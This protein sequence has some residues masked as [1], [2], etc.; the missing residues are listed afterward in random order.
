[1]V[2]AVANEWMEQIL[3]EHRQLRTTVA[4][5]REYLDGPRPRPGEKGSHTWAARLSERILHL[6]DELVRHF[7]FE[8]DTDVVEELT[9][10]H[11]EAAHEIQEV[12]DQHPVI[13][14]GIR[15]ITTD[16]LTYSEGKR[17]EDPHLRQRILSLLESLSEHEQRETHLIQRLEYREFGTGE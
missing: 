8:E 13:L 14:R 9:I 6:H 1:M 10:S 16:I 11:P 5:L 3:A 2:E 15:Q 7:R 4:D 17:P 12:L